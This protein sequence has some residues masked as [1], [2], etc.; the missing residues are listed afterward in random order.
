MDCIFCKIV[1]G[2]I[3]TEFIGE[4]EHAVAFKDLYP[5]APVHILVVPKS[6]SENISKMIIKSELEGVFDLIRTVTSEFTDGQ[7]KLQFN[8]GSREGQT[9]FHTHAHVLSQQSK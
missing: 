1:S 9:V 6:H 7:F 2:E 5:Q 4:N 3:P 8:S